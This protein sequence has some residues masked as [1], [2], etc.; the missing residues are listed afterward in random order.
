VRNLSTLFMASTLA[1]LGLTARAESPAPAAPSATA[2]PTPAPAQ[3]GAPAAAQGKGA[4]YYDPA[5]KPAPSRA[6]ESPSPRLTPGVRHHRGMYLRVDCGVGY[7]SQSWTQVGIDSQFTGPAVNL[8]SSIG[9]AIGEDLILAGRTFLGIAPNPSYTL[10][11][12]SAS[13]SGLTTNIVGFGP[14]LIYY[15]MPANVYL[16]ASVAI[17][18][19]TQ[20]LPDGTTRVTEIG[21]GSQA[22][23]GKE[24]WVGQRWAMGLAAQATYSSNPN[25]TFTVTG[26]N[27]GLVLSLTMN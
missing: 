18:R 7:Q 2:E 25:T 19:Q 26:L 16:S 8:G 24:W 3:D 11:G 20:N 6:G 17:T 14:E 9:G 5:Q 23:L 10:G 13:T 27:A 21:W 15:L 4:L 1:V 22:M 12:V